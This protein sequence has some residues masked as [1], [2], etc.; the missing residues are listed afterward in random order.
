MAPCVAQPSRKENPMS[1]KAKK[2][3]VILLSALLVLLAGAALV[4]AIAPPG[5]TEEDLAAAEAQTTC[6]GSP[7][8]KTGSGTINGTPGND[9]IIGSNR[10]DVI[11]GMGGDDKICGAGGDDS[12]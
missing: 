10:R 6:F 4:E 2:H 5:D 11:D 7:A 12:I 8:T 3:P 1:Y 9:V